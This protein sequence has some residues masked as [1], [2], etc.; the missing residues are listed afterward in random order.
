MIPSIIGFSSKRLSS[1]GVLEKITYNLFLASVKQTDG[2]MSECVC[3]VELNP[4]QHNWCMTCQA[5]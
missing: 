2:N 1:F 3:F 5:T 4:C